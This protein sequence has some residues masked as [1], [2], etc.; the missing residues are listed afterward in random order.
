MMELGLKFTLAYLIGAV[1]GSLL[2][3]FCY[4]GVDIRKVGSGNAGGTNALRTQGKLFALLVMVIDV[5]KGIL[6]AAVIP[7]LAIP[8]VGFDPDIDRSLVLYATAFAAIAGHVFPV[9]FGFRG[10]K[11]GAT[12][13]GLLCYLAPAAALPVIG[14]WLLIVLTTGFVGLATVSASLAAVV[15]L[16]FTALPQQSGLF[17]FACATAVLLMYAHR[18]NLQRMLNGTEARF[19]RPPLRRLFGGK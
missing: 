15:F 19:G 12:A 11:G 5:G 8:G 10:G 2:V 4:G 9:W 14:M 17:V 13:A 16:F 6:A 7:P 1:L 3:G 18:G